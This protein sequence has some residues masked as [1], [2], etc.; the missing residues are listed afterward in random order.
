MTD[1]FAGLETEWS[2]ERTRHI[3]E[4]STLE[5][6]HLINQEDA[7]VADRVHAALPQIALA[8]DAI[9]AR[10]KKGGH[11]IY[12]GAGTSGRLGILDAAECIPTYGTDPEL[13]QGHIAGGD[14][15]L[16]FP[17]EGCEDDENLGKQ[18]V[19]DC[20]VTQKDVVVGISASG[21]A[22][23]VIGALQEARDRG[24]CTVAIVN[25]CDSRAKEKAD[26]CIEVLTGPEVVSGSTRMK[27]GTAQKMVL[28]ML[29]TATMI[30]RGKVY[31]NLMV[32]V[33][34]TNQ[35]LKARAKRIFTAATGM[36]DAEAEKYLQLAEMDTK[37]AIMMALSGYDK[38][39]ALE[40]LA[41]WEDFLGKALKEADHQI[42][43]KV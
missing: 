27:A 43:E 32:D 31:G 38:E 40:K 23:F 9:C 41:E 15:A 19:Q 12:I 33:K 13:V 1:Y 37:L 34:A 17:I 21:S 29:S 11:L 36:D 25:N 22:R 10:M 20:A 39:H 24:A 2:N 26:I 14:M 3:D 30:K 7:T 8:V 4:C 16:R 6:L 35:K 18:T 28:N 5:I 42:E